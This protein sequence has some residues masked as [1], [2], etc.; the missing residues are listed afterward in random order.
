KMQVGGRT[1]GLP[2]GQLCYELALNEI[3]KAPG[4]PPPVPGDVAAP[5]ADAKKT[6]KEVAY[7]VL[8]RGAGGA[9]PGPADTVRVHYTGWTTDGRMFDSSHV[10]GVPSELALNGA[11]AG[12]T[13]AIPL[14][15]VGDRMRFWIPPQLAY[16]GAP[17]KPQGMLVFE[18]E[19]LELVKPAADTPLS[20]RQPAP[21]DV[22]APP[23]DAQKTEKGVSYKILTAK[24]GAPRPRPTD[25]IQVHYTGWTTAGEMFDSSRTAGKPAELPLPKMIEGWIDGIPRMGVGEKARFW[26]PEALAYKGEEGSPKGMLVFDVELLGIK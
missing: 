20:G 26:I 23:S 10:K 1:G 17:G 3:E 8:A 24:K 25:T 19:L 5:P 18:V 15:S 12:W 11:M 6:P 4:T 7:K 16:Q 13:E 22:A 14:M 9:K 2:S 21:A